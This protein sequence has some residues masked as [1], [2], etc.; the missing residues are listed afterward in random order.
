MKVSK[1]FV[2]FGILCVAVF[3]LVEFTFNQIF[4]DQTPLWKI[5]AVSLI[6]GVGLFHP[7]L[8]HKANFT[9]ADLLKK[10]YLKVELQNPVH[11]DFLKQLEIQLTKNGFIIT[12]MP[13]NENIICFKTNMSWHSMGE[14]YKLSYVEKE[15]RVVSKPKLPWSIF[16]LGI[17]KGRMNTIEEIILSKQKQLKPLNKK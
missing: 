8:K 17:T 14:I 13:A 10:Q 12:E 16:D 1:N 11:A 4:D 9:F 6:S 5:L 2:L 15:V 7:L 3:F